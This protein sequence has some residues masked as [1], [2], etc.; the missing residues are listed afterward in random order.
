[1]DAGWHGKSRGGKTGYRIFVFLIR[2]TGLAPAYCLL[3]FVAL[4]FI[5]ASASSTAAVWAYAR[6]MLK[7]GRVKS[8]LFV[9]GNYFSFGRSI[10]D[11]FAISAGLSGKFRYEFEGEECLREVLDSRGGAI[12]L[13][14]HFG[15]WAAGASFF[16]KYRAKMNMV[17]F[18]NEHA[19]IK[20]VMEDNRNGNA[21]FK[22]IPVNGDSLA[23]IFMIT[24]AL[25]RGELVCFMGDRYVD[26]SR[27]LETPFMGRP[28]EFPSGP[29]LLASRMNVPVV[30]YWS[31][32]ERNR[33]Y[34]FKFFRAACF[35]EKKKSAGEL[36]KEYAGS[37]EREVRLHPEQ[38]YNYYDFWNLRD[39]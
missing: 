11:K 28:A 2:H 29:F 10:I 19:D 18:D 23:H 13:S 6:K 17:M 15:N 26:G 12:V 3:A 21:S 39:E 35:T 4:Y 20:K 1:M 8:A 9:Y 22:M 5:P 33:T 7:Y 25:D 30:F 14:A 27:L 37:L 38:W 16:E 32:R 24:E 36:L 31:E 34:R